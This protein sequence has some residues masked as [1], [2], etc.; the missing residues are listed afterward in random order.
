MVKRL[1]YHY[2]KLTS[3]I[4]A[5]VISLLSMSMV[6][7]EPRLDIEVKGRDGQ[8]YSLSELSGQVIYIDF[9]ASW[10]GPCRKSFPWMDEMHNKYSDKGLKIV[11]INLD[12]DSTLADKFLQQLPAQ[13]SIAYDVEH[14]VAKE[15]E[16]LGMPSSYLFNRKG[17]LVST[18]VGFYG[19]NLMEYE[20]EIVKLLNESK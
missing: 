5:V 13:F 20:T 11:A 16:I 18:H 1:S 14:K 3:I 15:F 19:E 4:F 8:T 6:W 12:F 10:C 9:W 7:A 17:E 2:D